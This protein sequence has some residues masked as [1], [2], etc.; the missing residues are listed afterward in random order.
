MTILVVLQK[1]ITIHQLEATAMKYPAFA[2]I[3]HVGK[4]DWL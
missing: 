3:S 2:P 1:T 4:L